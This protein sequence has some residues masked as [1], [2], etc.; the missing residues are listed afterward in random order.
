M[1]E[2]T[3]VP[4]SYW[5]QPEGRWKKEGASST[6]IQLGLGV[7]PSQSIIEWDLDNK[8]FNPWHYWAL[9]HEPFESFIELK[10][11]IKTKKHN[12]LSKQNIHPIHILLFLNKENAIDIWEKHF[13]FPEKDILTCNN[14]SFL[15]CAAWSGN[16]QNVEKILEMFQSN[17]LINILNDEHLTPLMIA[18]NW[19]NLAMVE[20][21]LKSGA[22]PEISSDKNQKTALHYAASNNDSLVFELLED[23]GADREAKDIL[24]KTPESI[25]SNKKN[26]LGMH[27]NKFFWQNKKEKRYVW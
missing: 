17:N 26:N 12:Q 4:L 2:K 25:L 20:A 7:S 24:G 21:L 1:Q 16:H 22:N 23:Y 9:S 8:G 11:R 27:S 14:D 19:G 15:H 10:K 13:A 6:L 3:I 5:E 18:V